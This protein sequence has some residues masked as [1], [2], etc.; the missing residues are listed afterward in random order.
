MMSSIDGAEA[1]LVDGAPHNFAGSVEA[2][3]GSVGAW[4][5][6]LES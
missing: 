2:L 3:A 5:N 4:L 1:V 6:R